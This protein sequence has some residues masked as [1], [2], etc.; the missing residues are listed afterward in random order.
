M[1]IILLGVVL[2]SA[3]S[4]SGK[5]I[6]TGRS[7]IV[8]NNNNQSNGKATPTFDPPAYTPGRFPGC[9]PAPGVAPYQSKVQPPDYTQTP[10]AASLREL[11]SRQGRFIGVAAAPE[12]LKD[13]NYSQLLARE[14]NL[15][16]PENAMKW[17]VIH[18]QPEQYDFS[19]GDQ[20]IDFARQHNMSVRGHVLVWDLQMPEW[21][22]QAEHTRSEWMNILCVHIKTVLQ[23]YQGVIYAWDVVNE[24]VNDDGTLRNTFWMERIGPEYIAMAFQWAREADPSARLFYNDNGGEGLNPKSQAIYMLAQEMIRQSIPL[25]GIGLQMHTDLY[26]SPPPSDLAANIRRLTDLGLEVHITEIDVRLQT[27]SDPEPVRL[28]AQAE[29]Y[30]QVIST[31]LDFPRCRAFVTWGL[32]DRYSWIP[33]WT[34]NPDAPLLFDVNG[35]PK[36]AYEAVREAFLGR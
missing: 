6:L 30:R 11:A 26:Q 17:E 35:A 5:D 24:A 9:Q 3:C 25:D 28:A 32:T 1:A 12:L 36:P 22:T 15:V 34:G 20:L 27:S 10:A 18:P 14:F 19:P 8:A 23:H 13:S 21:V 29:V 31:C 16:T 2:F 7:S 33:Y 4:Y